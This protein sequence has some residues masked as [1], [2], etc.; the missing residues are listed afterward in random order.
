MSASAA[1]VAVQR[2]AS[3]PTDTEV[4]LWTCQEMYVYQIPPL[5]NE[6]G[7]RANDWDVNKWLW[8]GKLSVFSIG[9]VVQVRL[10]DPTSGALF[11]MCPVNEPG[12]KA[13]D[14]VVDSS[15]YFVLRI[16]DGKGRHAFIG[17]GFR[18]RDDSYNFNATLQ[19]HW[20][21]VARQKEADAIR[22]EAEAA[23]AEAPL[24]D[25][26]L[27]DGEKIS[28]KVNLPKGE[29]RRS[30]EKAAGGGGLSLPPPPGGGLI[31]PPPKPGMLAP[32]PPPSP[33]AGPAVPP[34]APPAAAIDADDFGDFAEAGGDGGGDDFGDFAAADGAAGGAADGAGNADGAEFGE[35]DATPA[36]AAEDAAGGDG[37]SAEAGAAKPRDGIPLD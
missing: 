13:I 36:A 34:G 8:S 10:T 32:P 22:E 28:I 31:A 24:R 5:K 33:A 16:D 14:P 2:I 9:N 11:A 17:M 6:S 30:R 25:L 27:K 19:D 1:P 26:S 3:G 7:H 35:L 23:A 29:G 18:D 15:R 21:G 12:S 4:L 20:K 37:A